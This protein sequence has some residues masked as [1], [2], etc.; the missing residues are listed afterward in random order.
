MIRPLKAYAWKARQW[1]YRRQMLR[2]AALAELNRQIVKAR[3]NHAPVKP[4]YADYAARVN[5]LLG[6]AR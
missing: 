6:G 5:Q 4:L 1:W 3:K 2:D